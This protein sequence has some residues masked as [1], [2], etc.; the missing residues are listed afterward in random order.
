[1]DSCAFEISLF[2]FNIVKLIIFSV[3]PAWGNFVGLMNFQLNY[4]ILQIPLNLIHVLIHDVISIG[5]AHR[6]KATFKLLCTGI[7]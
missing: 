7:H 3:H 6:Q 1:M 5:L 4:E 2:A